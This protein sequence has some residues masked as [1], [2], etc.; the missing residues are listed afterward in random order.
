MSCLIV[1]DLLVVDLLAETESVLHDLIST[2][3]KCITQQTKSLKNGNKNNIIF[4]IIFFSVSL[5]VKGAVY[6]S[7]LQ[8][9][10][11]I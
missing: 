5:C 7:I 9:F 2:L 10:I 6:C 8:W 1:S 4:I 3:A 11:S